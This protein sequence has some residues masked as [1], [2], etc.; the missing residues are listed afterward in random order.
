MGMRRHDHHAIALLRQA[1]VVD[2]AASAGDETGILEPRNRLANT[3]FCHAFSP[4]RAALK[5]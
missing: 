5:G 3:E 4:R 2:I 1:D